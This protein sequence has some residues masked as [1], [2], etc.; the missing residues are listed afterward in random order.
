MK[1]LI[2]ILLL[3]LILIFSQFTEDLSGNTLPVVKK[4]YTKGSFVFGSGF[5][6]YCVKDK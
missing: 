5:D 2:Y 3:T 1:Y 6:I 4:L